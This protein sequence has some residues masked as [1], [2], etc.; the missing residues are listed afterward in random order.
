MSYSS[1]IDNTKTPT[2]RGCTVGVFVCEIV[3]KKI[4]QIN[5]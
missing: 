2:E 1:L 3:Q 4:R 5:I